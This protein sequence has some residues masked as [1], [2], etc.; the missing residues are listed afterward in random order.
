MQDYQAMIHYATLAPSGHNTQPWRFEIEGDAIRVMPDFSRRLP[1]VDPDDHALYISLGCA[2]ENLVIAAGYFGYAAETCYEERGGEPGSLFIRLRRS[3]ASGSS[4][5]FQAIPKRQ[6][7]RR[8]YDRRPIPAEH[9]RMLL[10]S[11]AGEGVSALAVSA[12]QEIERLTPY[13]ARASRA[14][15]EDQAFLSEL[16]QWIRFS[17]REAE[18]TRDGIP[19]AALGLPPAPRW[20]GKLIMRT[21]AGPSSEA[22]RQ[23]KLVRSS[24]ALFLFVAECDD[25]PHW[26]ELGRA[27]ERMA[28]T[29]TALGI[30]HAHVNMPCEVLPVRREMERELE[31]SPRHALLLVRMGYGRPIARSLRRSVE[32][33]IQG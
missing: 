6:T 27:F 29:A 18:A 31:I 30:Q 8:L 7:N 9:L 2:V 28:L 33:V 11:A 17:R 10:E 15:F 4:D 23:A 12:P 21:F 14:Q 32:E 25:R 26:I 19:A 22:Q 20:L 16:I 3:R 13:V 1:V 5:F 24:S